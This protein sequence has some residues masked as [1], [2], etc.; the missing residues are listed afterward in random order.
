M[1]AQQMKR[2]VRAMDY[3][4]ENFADHYQDCPEYS[5]K[6]PGVNCECG[7]KAAL[8]DIEKLRDR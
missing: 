3:M 2:L 4:I 6:H 1:N 5:P 7:Y 8:A